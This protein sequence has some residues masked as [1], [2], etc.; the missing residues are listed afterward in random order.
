MKVYCLIF[1]GFSD[2]ETGY[3]LPELKNNGVEIVTVGFST[4]PVE[5]M[6]GLVVVPHVELSEVNAEEADLL[7]VPGGNRW[8]NA[9][10]ADEIGE[11]L[12]AYQ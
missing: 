8:H 3:V 9:E 4:D 5:S 10:L 11:L 12:Q 7:I 1:D 2:W 6:G